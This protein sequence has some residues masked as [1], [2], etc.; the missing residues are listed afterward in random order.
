MNVL[1]FFVGPIGRW[2]VVTALVASAVFAAGVHE[3]NIGWNERDAQAKLED[4]Q[5]QKVEADAIAK[6]HAKRLAEEAEAA[7]QQARL[8]QDF[9]KEM[10]DAKTQHD[11]DVAAARAGSLVLRLP[12]T[13]S[14][15]LRVPD[16]AVSGDTQTQGSQLPPE[17]TANLFGLADDADA[18]VKDD[19]YC[20]S[21]VAADRKK[22]GTQ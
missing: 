22:N 9:E 15:S 8:K 18:L 19:N 13:G 10:A 1:A 4:A 21:I 20:W 6:E 7:K 12:S 5:R 3:R 16:S 17:V 2:L 14:G 11:K